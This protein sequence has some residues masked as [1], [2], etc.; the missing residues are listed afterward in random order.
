VVASHAEPRGPHLAVRYV[1]FIPG[2]NCTVSLSFMAAGAALGR[3]KYVVYSEQGWQCQPIMGRRGGCTWP[4][5][6]C[7]VFLAGLALVAY[8]SEPRVPNLGVRNMACIPGKD[9]RVSL[10]SFGAIGRSRYVVYSGQGWQYEPT[11]RSQP[12][13][14]ARIMLCIPCRGCF[15]SLSFGASGE[16]IGPF[17]ICRVFRAL[18][19][20]LSHHSKTAAP[21]RSKYVVYSGHGLHHSSI[22]R[23][24]GGGAL[25]RSKYVVYSKQK[26][27]Y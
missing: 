16:H 15:I 23:G 7:F 18:V 9:C 8:H 10:L 21:G 11:I 1:V 6:I 3:S 5:E 12:H 17:E 27:Q 24:R 19:A 4:L 25:G 20:V 13:W 2:R 26:L 14:T 22:I